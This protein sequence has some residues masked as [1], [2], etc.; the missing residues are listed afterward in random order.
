VLSAHA[1]VCS[2]L[3]PV[4]APTSMQEPKGENTQ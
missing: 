3:S 1:R 2:T 4:I